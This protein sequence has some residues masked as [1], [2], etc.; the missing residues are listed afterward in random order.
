MVVLIPPA[1]E[2]RRI[3]SRVDELMAFCDQLQTLLATSQTQ[4][5]TFL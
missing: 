4:N 2:Q 3:V 1:A 5:R